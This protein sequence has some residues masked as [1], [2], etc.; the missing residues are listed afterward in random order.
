MEDRSETQEIDEVL[1]M[2]AVMQ[3]PAF[4]QAVVTAVLKNESLDFNV[5]PDTST[6]QAIR[7]ADL[8]LE[9]F[10]ERFS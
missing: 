2:T 9:A 1:R 3:R 8:A 5:R 7:T 6:R 4:W 10:D